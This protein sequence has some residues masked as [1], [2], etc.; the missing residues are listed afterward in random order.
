M[1]LYY[2]S[3]DVRFANT[4]LGNSCLFSVIS[5][6]IDKGTGVQEDKEFVQVNGAP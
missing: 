3:Q 1:C 6:F 4:V 2:S 5:S